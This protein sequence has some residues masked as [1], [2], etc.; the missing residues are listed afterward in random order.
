MFT[1]CSDALTWQFNCNWCY[2]YCTSY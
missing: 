1:Y 2:L